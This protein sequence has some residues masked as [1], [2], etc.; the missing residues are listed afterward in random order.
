MIKQ[1][2]SGVSH[3]SPWDG[4]MTVSQLATKLDHAAPTCGNHGFLHS[5]HTLLYLSKVGRPRAHHLVRVLYPYHEV[6]G[7]SPS[8]G[9]GGTFPSISQ[10]S[11]WSEQAM[12]SIPSSSSFGATFIL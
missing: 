5:N 7:L 4:K 1:P 3:L 6:S 9:H 10:S 11:L 2:Y 8:S 12:S